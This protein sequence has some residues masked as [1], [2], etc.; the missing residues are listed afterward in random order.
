MRNQPREILTTEGRALISSS[1]LDSRDS[2]FC[3]AARRG[4]SA[5][6][7]E[8][9]KRGESMEELS[10]AMWISAARGHP[11]CL[12]MLV[13]VAKPRAEKSLALQLAARFGRDMCVAILIPL[14]TPKA[15]GSLALKWAIQGGHIA[16]ARLLIPVSD[17]SDRLGMGRLAE[18]IALDSKRVNMFALLESVKITE[19]LEEAP[20]RH[21]RSLRI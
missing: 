14:S 13:A 15:D 16:C 7:A 3:A 11:E 17:L 6:V 8:A 5:S 4:D 2:P 9:I 18:E 21:A 12:E 19:S 1:H 20:A 10:R